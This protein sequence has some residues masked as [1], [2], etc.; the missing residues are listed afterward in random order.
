MR[1]ARQRWLLVACCVRPSLAALRRDMAVQAPGIDNA[2]SPTG[3][4]LAVQVIGGGR[5]IDG[6]GVLGESVALQWRSGVDFQACIFMQSLMQVPAS[7][8]RL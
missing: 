5:G 6:V 7:S 8:P 2:M 3:L 1:P 4:R